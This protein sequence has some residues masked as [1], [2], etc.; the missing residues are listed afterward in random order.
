[1]LLESPA[2]V[3]TLARDY[4]DGAL[5]SAVQQLNLNLQFTTFRKLRVASSSITDD[6]D[7]SV[8]LR[9]AQVEMRVLVI[10]VR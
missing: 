5:P 8:P 7:G 3:A 10:H 9:I 6:V 1:M 2:P 4:Q